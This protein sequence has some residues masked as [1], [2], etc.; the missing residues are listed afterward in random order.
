MSSQLCLLAALVV[1]PLVEGWVVPEHRVQK[2]GLTR[3][4]AASF[5][6]SHSFED[7]NDLNGAARAFNQDG[8]ILETAGM[9]REGPVVK[10]PNDV[11]LTHNPTSHHIKPY[12]PHHTTLHQ[13]SQHAT[14]RRQ[15]NQT[16]LTHNATPFNCRCSCR[17]LSP[18]HRGRA[19]EPHPARQLGERAE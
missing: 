17:E 18:S 10:K 13:R 14:R 5:G 11:Y 16:S 19:L 1:P 12:Q 8:L 7:Q 6:S 4:N 3:T 9:Y 2:R 15:K